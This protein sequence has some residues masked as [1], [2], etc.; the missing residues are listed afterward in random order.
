[1]G[2]IVCE[3]EKWESTEFEV[4]G[5]NHFSRGV[6]LEQ[7]RR[8]PHCSSVIYSRRHKQCG[9]CGEALPEG[10]LFSADE[11][12]SVEALLDDERQRHR[13]WLQRFSYAPPGSV[14]ILS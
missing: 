10:C 6:K 12:R 9:V 1:M 14:W 3:V 8:C 11:A 13:K 7:E 4:G 5:P 2:A